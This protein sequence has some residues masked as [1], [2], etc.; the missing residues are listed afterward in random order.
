MRRAVTVLA[1]MA[2]LILP[3][4]TFAATQQ[5]FDWSGGP[6]YSHS[7]VEGKTL[8]EISEK[9]AHEAVLWG[10]PVEYKTPDGSMDLKAYAS[11]G[12]SPCESVN[13]EAWN[14]GKLVTNTT[15][16]FCDLSYP[17]DNLT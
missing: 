14:H 2:I 16:E 15:T 7:M 10:Y 5:K 17:V 1:C 13:V 3:L 8:A 12:K 11:F 9:A 4:G 6:K